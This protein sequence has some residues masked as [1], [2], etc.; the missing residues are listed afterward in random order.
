MQ[1][2]PDFQRDTI[3]YLLQKRAAASPRDTAY[4]FPE[5]QQEYTWLTIWDQVKLAAKGFMQLGI[6]RGEA[7]ALLMPGRMEMVVSM[8][9]AASIG[10]IVVPINT[11]LHRLYQF[12]IKNEFHSYWERHL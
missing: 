2:G 5:F 11:Y 8:Y 12:L 3:P 9:A 7:I 10:A 1:D 6:N 4:S